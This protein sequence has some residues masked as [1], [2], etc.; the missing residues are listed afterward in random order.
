MLPSH[1]G[2]CEENY[3]IY[4]KKNLKYQTCKACKAIVEKKS[5]CDRIKCKCGNIFCYL[6]GKN[7]GDST[8]HSCQM[9]DLDRENGNY[10]C[11]SCLNDCGIAGCI[12]KLFIKI[13]VCF[14]I[15]L[16]FSIAWIP[17]MLFYMGLS[18]AMVSIISI[19][20]TC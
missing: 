6:C 4:F 15:F 2:S 3:L 12:L 13:F 16:V 1:A 19:C 18:V 10:C 7:L 14:P 9:R 17:L 11:C 20:L 8:P 5:G